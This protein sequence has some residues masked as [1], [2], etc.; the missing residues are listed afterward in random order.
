MV[1]GNPN[2]HMQKNNDGHVRTLH[3]RQKWT[4][5]ESNFNIRAKTIKPLLEFLH[6]S[7]VSW[8]LAMISWL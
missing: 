2:I 1:L 8:H 6:K 4:Q 7:K 3:N 5:R